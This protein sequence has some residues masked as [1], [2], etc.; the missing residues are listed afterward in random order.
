MIEASQ[1]AISQKCFQVHQPLILIKS[2]KNQ[3]MLVQL[4]RTNHASGKK[5]LTKDY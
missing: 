5:D 1:E 4:I 3:Y 2:P